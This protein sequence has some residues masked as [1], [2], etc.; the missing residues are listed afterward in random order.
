M[1]TS[2]LLNQVLPEIAKRKTSRRK[3]LAKAATAAGIVAG[4]GLIGRSARPAAAALT[5]TYGPKGHKITVDDNDILNF[6]LNLEYVEAEF[7]QR[8]AFGLG[9]LDTNSAYTSGTGTLGTVNGGSQVAFTDPIV[10]QYAQEIATDELN[11]VLFL[12][13][14][15]STAAVARPSID[16]TNAF[17]AAARAAGV[18]D[19]SA[20]TFD[21]FNANGAFTPDVSF[22]LGSFIFEDVGVTAYQGGAPYIKN[23]VYLQK[24]AG[25]LAVEAMHAAEIRTTLYRTAQAD[26]SNAILVAADQISSARETLSQAADGVAITDE[27]IARGGPGDATTANLVPN[28][29]NGMTFSRS[30]AAVLNIVYLGGYNVTTQTGA[31]GFFPNGMN[32][33]IH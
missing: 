15:L 26:N 18:V 19:A 6:A 22:L 11:H 13:Q 10:Q 24:L 17:T 27:G 1:S 14:A 32:G 8:A 25:I 4:S 12:R 21:P 2:S 28:N 3:L 20:G 5:A 33:R 30:F 16:F 29:M 23:S 9:A 7:Y 31:G